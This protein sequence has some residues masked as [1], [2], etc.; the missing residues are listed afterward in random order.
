ME[1]IRL[2]RE[3]HRTAAP[4]GVTVLSE[5]VASVRSAAVGVWVRSASAHEP[6]P[7]M[8]VSHLLEHMVFKGT[9]RRSAQEIALA[10]EARG[11]SLDAYT[12]RDS[13]AYHARVLDA[14]LPRALDVISDL[15]RRPLLRDTDLELERKVILEEI[16]TVDDTPD[17]LVFDQ[18]YETLW[19]EH[20]YGYQILGT[21]DTVSAL[22]TD[23]LKALHQRAYFPGNSVIAA[24]GNF[25]HE[26]LL[27]EV[28]KQGWFD[29][30]EGR[31]EKDAPV[32]AP[33]PA[34]VR[35]VQRHF[36]KDTAQTHIVFAT[37]TVP[38]ADRR[39]YALL[40]LSNI[41][42]GGMSSRL[43][44]R[45]R[46]ELGLAYAVYSFT[47]FYR[48]MGVAGVYV[49]TQPARAAEATAAIRD[50]LARL[51]RDG[52]AGAALADAK[53][54]TQGQLM[55]SL[56]SPT[57]RM[58]RLASTAVF[59]EPYASL[60]EMLGLV[61]ALTADDTAAAAAEFF[62]PGRQTVVSLGPA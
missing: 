8:G 49:G 55:L 23:D 3:I 34:A 18:A 24:A 20:P 37:D 53:Q 4:N 50:E 43:F 42:G 48:A 7:K 58:Y 27:A 28:A 46:E 12:S 36:E 52:L 16:S 62:D 26:A 45:I 11:G 51:A 29:R 30:G 22:S 41:F 56:E 40:V 33:V 1:T 44:Q 9:E 6:R 59:G 14:D 17:D 35:G 5:R 25:E 21:R 61:A 47:S 38:Y 60:D 13:T 32:A 10:L 19:P 39:K 57:A 2:D 54:Q 31:G 15:V